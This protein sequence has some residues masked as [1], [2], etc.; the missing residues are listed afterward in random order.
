MGNHSEMLHKPHGLGFTG[1]TARYHRDLTDIFERRFADELVRIETGQ[2]D[3]GMPLNLVGSADHMLL[4]AWM[5]E[6]SFKTAF[7]N[8]CMVG[9]GFTQ[10]PD[11]AGPN[12]KRL[13]IFTPFF[14]ARMDKR[15]RKDMPDGS[16]KAI[17]QS[18][19]DTVTPLAQAVR[20]VV[21]AEYLAT[22]DFHS[23]RAAQ[24][25][26]K[27]GVAV[28]NLTAA[29]LLANE[30]GHM[31]KKTKKPW[32]VAIADAGALNHAAP[33]HR[34]LGN[35]DLAIFLKNR[36][37]V[38][39]GV[40]NEVT[41]EL[42]HGSVE[43]RDVV[44]LDDSIS[45]GKTSAETVTAVKQHGAASIVYCATHPLFVGDY[46]QTLETIL[47][48]PKVTRVITTDSLPTKHRSRPAPL[49]YAQRANGSFKEIDVVHVG[50]FL[51]GCA[52]TILHS[53]SVAEAKKQLGDDVWNMK[54]PEW[55]FETFTGR[56]L[57]IQVDAGVYLGR[58]RFIPLYQ[59][60]N[61]E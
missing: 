19:S 40:K 12:A 42:V 60:P 5:P 48:D 32:V 22:L 25:F 34:Q 4:L 38:G 41:T 56:P 3:N 53:D 52:Y 37:P 11:A 44:V 49:P 7:T 30:L 35:A 61:Q 13:G 16:G 33:L 31:E 47:E 26:E 14:D 51:A 36:N 54:E 39:E 20:H 2:F 57:P 8:L 1:E 45:S 15:G 29:R 27:E 24:I 21:H 50:E 10:N 9:S 43:D 28:I 46:Y 23:Y 17:I 59:R 18:Q 58:Q 55:L 6:N